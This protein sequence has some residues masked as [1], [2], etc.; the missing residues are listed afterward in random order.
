MSY[1]GEYPQPLARTTNV[2]CPVV[3]GYAT[4]RLR[5]SD[6]LFGSGNVGVNED[7]AQSTV[8]LENT[9]QNS[10]TVQLKGTWVTDPP[11][12]DS[13]GVPTGTRI[14]VGSAVA[15]VPGGHKTMSIT[16]YQT[17]LEVYGEANGPSN[18]RIQ[19][20]SKLQWDQMAFDKSDT[21][22]PAVLRDVI[23]VPSAPSI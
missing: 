14:N 7:A 4:A 15:L 1:P 18:L 13:T 2:L 19:I 8:T 16:P 17:Y 6:P 11:G 10:V 22:Y 12:D 9:G 21:L 23:P 5:R 3:N 20:S